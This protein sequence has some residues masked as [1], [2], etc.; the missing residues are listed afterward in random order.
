M[1]PPAK[2]PK[3]VG[4][5]SYTQ[6]AR[7]RPPPP[8]SARASASKSDVS[9]NLP[10][11]ARSP[12]D[13]YATPCTGLAEKYYNN[14]LGGTGG[15]TTRQEWTLIEEIDALDNFN[16]EEERRRRVK[17]KNASHQAQ[18]V[19]QLQARR[20]VTDKCR[21]VWCQWRTELEEDVLQYAKE[22]EQKKA[23]ILAE[24]K[25]FNQERDKQLADSHRRRAMQK[26]QDMKMEREMMQEAEQ[27]KIRQDAAD[28][29]RKMKQRQDMQ[30][31]K[32]QADE[33]VE[34]R[35]IARKEENARDLKMQKEYEELLD[36]QERNRHSYFANIRDK[37]KKL[38]AKYEQGVGNRLAELQAADDERA[39]RQQHDKEMRE[40]MDHEA[41][42]RWRKDLAASGHVAVQNQ[43]AIQAEQRQKLRDEE[44]RYLEKARMEAAIAEAKELERERKKKEAVLANAEFVRKQIMEREAVL[45]TKK[46]GTAQMTDV[47][48][49]LNREKLERACDPSRAD[50]LQSLLGRKRSEYRKMNLQRGRVMVGAAPGMA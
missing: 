12:K 44:H 42:E 41:R 5:A 17:E 2:K 1:F 40:R 15:D 27:A 28:A 30:Q 8:Q 19:E 36:E 24:Q 43:L 6:K 13:G 7:A 47:E 29:R 37:Q 4:G 38:L 32:T 48:R 18:L 26:E 46:N 39:R 14:L 50:G 45:P 20:N 33:A 49:Q 16:K 23:Y 21:D 9:T 25:R 3:R 34:R 22:E 35:A 31:M 10:L 11:S